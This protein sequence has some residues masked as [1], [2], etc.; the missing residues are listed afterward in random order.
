V[1]PLG[2]H[3][4]GAGKKER[5]LNVNDTQ[6]KLNVYFKIKDLFILKKINIHIATANHEQ[7]VFYYVV[8]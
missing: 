6:P 1:K 2:N 7:F 8:V 3:H 4:Q 5:N